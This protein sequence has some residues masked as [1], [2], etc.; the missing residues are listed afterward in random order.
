VIPIPPFYVSLLLVLVSIA[1]IASARRNARLLR[2]R[3]DLLRKKEAAFKMIREIENYS[4][5]LEG[6]LFEVRKV[7]DAG[8]GER[9]VQ[10]ARRAVRGSERL[11]S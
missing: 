1:C 9:T 8:L 3:A 7:L 5:H 6:E 2:E 11:S 4:Q 10:A